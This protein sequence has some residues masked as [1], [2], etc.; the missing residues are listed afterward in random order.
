MMLISLLLRLNMFLDHS[1]NNNKLDQ[2]IADTFKLFITN[3]TQITLNLPALSWS[4]D[5]SF[6]DLIMNPIQQQSYSEIADND[7]NIFKPLIFNLFKN[8][9][10]IT[11][12]TGWSSDVY[13][14]N[15]LSLLSVLTDYR[16]FV[17]T[18]LAFG[19]LREYEDAHNLN[20]PSEIKQIIGKYHI[21]QGLLRIIIKSSSKWITNKFDSKSKDEYA[22]KQVHIDFLHNSVIISV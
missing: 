13:S 11:I 4:E 15:M 1:P 12:I 14:F 5:S 21:Y 9:K 7:I 17:S 2:Y 18:V 22:A 19:Y 16:S 6:I 10:E 3:K 20:I 8:L